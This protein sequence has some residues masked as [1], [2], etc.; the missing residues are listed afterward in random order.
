MVNLYSTFIVADNSGAKV[1]KCLNII[2]RKSQNIIV[3]DIIL[4]V[5]KKSI[6][7][8]LIKKSDIVKG[9]VIRT[10]KISNKDM[11]FKISFNDNAVVLINK[12]ND[13]IGKRIFG[14][15]SSELYKSKFFKIISLAEN[16][17]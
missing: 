4:G 11:F 5:V 15:V 10:K 6:S 14:S 9:V 7:N 12:N 8:V 2:N 17:V 13:L 3:G 1:I 16:I